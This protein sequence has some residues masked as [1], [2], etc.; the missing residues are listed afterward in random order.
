MSQ[1]LWDCGVR[2]SPMTRRLAE[3]ER[4]DPENVEFTLALLDPRLVAG[5]AAVCGEAGG[6]ALPKLLAQGAQGDRDASWLELTRTR[7]A[8]YGETLFHLEPNIKDC[9]GGLRDVHVCGWLARLRSG[10]TARSGGSAGES[11]MQASDAEFQRG[12]GVSRRC[13]A[14]CTTGTSATTTRWT[15]RRRMRRRR[16]RI[17]LWRPA[18][19]GGA[20][21]AA[22][23][24]RLYFRH[25]RSVERR[26]S[27]DAE[28]RLPR[29]QRASCAAAAGRSGRACGARRRRVSRWSRDGRRWMRRVRARGRSGARSGCGAAAVCGDGADGLRAGPGGEERLSQ[30]L[31]LLSAHLE[32]GPAL[33]QQLRAILTGPHAGEALRAMHALGVLELLIPEFHGIDALVIR[34]AYHRYTVDEHTFVLID[35]LHGLAAPQTRARWASGRRSLAQLLRELPHPELLYLA[36]LLHDTGKGRST[37]DHAVESARMARERAGAAGAGCV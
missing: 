15:G 11:A 19:A 18:N 6:Q 8:K 31:P 24:M 1:E 16:Q 2:V 7:H 20:A 27:A 23:W 32:E 22:Y 37:G 29:P 12:G 21:D 13:G 28:A 35:T 30:A 17:G 10:R 34:D 5:D 33:W 9:P 25:A 4:F 3:C 14:F 36:A 26:V